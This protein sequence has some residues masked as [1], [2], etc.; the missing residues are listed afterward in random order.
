MIIPCAKAFLICSG[1][2]GFLE[3]AGLVTDKEYLCYLTG[4]GLLVGELRG[5]CGAVLADV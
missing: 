2:S 3:A 1:H 4:N 5:K